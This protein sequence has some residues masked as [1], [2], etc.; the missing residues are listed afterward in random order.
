MAQNTPKRYPQIARMSLFQE[1]LS[2]HIQC[3]TPL[4]Q[5]TVTPTWENGGDEKLKRNKNGV[6]KEDLRLRKWDKAGWKGM[7]VNRK[8]SSYK[9]PKSSLDSKEYSFD[10]NLE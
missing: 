7:M 9:K 6:K 5:R 2:M 8:R 4:Q 10:T 3:A 1:R